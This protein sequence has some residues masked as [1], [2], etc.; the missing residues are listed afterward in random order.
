M[1]FTETFQRGGISTSSAETK[2]RELESDSTPIVHLE[3]IHI[4]QDKISSESNYLIAIHQDGKVGCYT[5]WLDEQLWTKSLLQ[6]SQ[7]VVHATLTTIKQASRTLLRNRRDVVALLDSDD[8]DGESSLLLLVT[9]DSEHAQTGNGN[10][11]DLRIF[12][13]H[14]SNID[15]GAS[16]LDSGNPVQELTTI[17]VRESINMKAQNCT[18]RFHVGSGT[19]YQQSPNCLALYSMTD[20][21]PKMTHEIVLHGK[22]M[23]SFQRLTPENVAISTGSTVTIVR[24]PYRSIQDEI[25]LESLQRQTEP[26]SQITNDVK[27]VS[28]IT[29]FSTLVALHG[30][31][32]AVLRLQ[33]ADSTDRAIR[34]RKRGNLLAESIGHGTFGE[35]NGYKLG[36]AKKSQLGVLGTQFSLYDDSLMAES[37]AKMEE[38][39]SQAD[40][41]PLSTSDISSIVMNGQGPI[42]VDHSR[43]ALLMDKIF[44]VDMHRSPGP[45]SYVDLSIRLLPTSLY[46]WLL[47]QGLFNVDTIE[48]S[49]KRCSSIPESAKISPKSVISALAKR[50]DNLQA[51]RSLVSSVCP[52][53]L[54]ELV[55][56]LP[57]FMEHWINLESSQGQKLLTN[58]ETGNGEL[59][60]EDY[61]DDMKPSPFKNHRSSF[62]SPLL[63]RLSKHQKV[64]I[65]H[66]FRTRLLK[67]HLVKLVDIL[68]NLIAWPGWLAP[69]ED[70]SFASTTSEESQPN[71]AA[72]PLRPILQILSA[73]I[74]AMGLG[75]WLLGSRGSTSIGQVD[76]ADQIGYMRAEI[77]AAL[78]ST[79]EAVYLSGLLEEVLLCGKDHLSS[80]HTNEPPL[81]RNHQV[82]G[83]AETAIIPATT[84]TAL[85][86]N[87]TSSTKPPGTIQTIY[88]PIDKD[89]GLG[90]LEGKALPLGLKLAPKIPLRKIGAGGEI[91]VRSKRDIGR[92]KSRQ[93]P[94]YSIER[95]T[96]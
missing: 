90:S 72:S 38:L 68:R 66:E 46:D 63:D 26:A 43:L 41:E 93:V 51:L 94:K 61:G 25:T 11:L 92:L 67:P 33:G 45:I 3:P 62:F 32:L 84:T 34:K 40:F 86:T 2:L 7:Q 9:Q 24:L 57:Y 18:F 17:K 48:R 6:K 55:L 50:D 59:N 54:S 23:T 69:Y 8:D 85:T 77:S 5:T 22:K 91:I 29:P 13:I 49:L 20:L 12:S 53:G 47:S 95:I 42:G 27:L 75:G 31:R 30:R 35:S 14:H 60:L 10:Y 56:M 70:L 74:D 36:Q 78:E 89:L 65:T 79:E 44:S 71:P 96:V 16:S 52:L 88:S 4:A 76:S 19:I 80:R 58:H 15:G 1:R 37:K 73:A 83:A 28:Y 21:V 64:Q 39:L 87:G 82:D 81:I